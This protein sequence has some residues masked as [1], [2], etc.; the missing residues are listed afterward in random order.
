MGLTD[1]ELQARMKAQAEA[2][3]EKLFVEKKAPDEISLRPLHQN[4]PPKVV[5]A[6]YGQT[7]WA[8]STNVPSVVRVD[9]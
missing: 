3:I 4:K 5:V 1:N 6:Q 7:T 9:T 8:K 2:A